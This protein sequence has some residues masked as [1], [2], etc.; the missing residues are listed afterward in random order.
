MLKDHKDE[1]EVSMD[2]TLLNVAWVVGQ[3]RSAYWGGWRSEDLIR[4]SL[5][6]SLNFGLY[7]VPPEN[8]GWGGKITQVGF[9]RVVTDSTTFHWLCDVIIRE[10][11][12]R[13]GLGTM[14][15]EKVLAYPD[16]KT[17]VMMLG[18]KDAH[19]F[20]EKFGFAKSEQMKRI[21]PLTL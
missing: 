10:D 2:D 4:E 5:K 19:S 12:R 16:F 9:A 17:G 14:L 1:F 3:I 13:K 6:N 7:W 18:T 15:V 11:L 8:A 21:P 20:Y